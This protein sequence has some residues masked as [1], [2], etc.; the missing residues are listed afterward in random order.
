MEFTKT[1][2]ESILQVMKTVEKSLEYNFKNEQF[3]SGFIR[4]KADQE[5]ME[6]LKE[7]NEKIN[8]KIQSTN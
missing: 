4:F 2:L 3:E 8:A 1:E 5:E 6:F 7:L